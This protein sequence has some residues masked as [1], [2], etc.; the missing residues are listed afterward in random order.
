VTD[1]HPLPINEAACEKSGCAWMHPEAECLWVAEQ[2]RARIIYHRVS[3]CCGSRNEESASASGSKLQGSRAFQ[4]SLMKRCSL[5]HQA[6]RDVWSSCSPEPTP[7]ACHVAGASISR[8]FD[9]VRRQFAPHSER[10]TRRATEH[11][12]RATRTPIDGHFSLTCDSRAISI[13]VA[14]RA[15]VFKR[16]SWAC[17]L[18]TSTN[19]CTHCA[20]IATRLRA[21]CFPPSIQH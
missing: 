13:H 4:Y 1:N 19:G 8:K 17:M 18:D 9:Q 5:D 11:S 7:P 6:R 12:S 20:S 15:A 3:L 2:H 14:P 21:V 10:A 16:Y